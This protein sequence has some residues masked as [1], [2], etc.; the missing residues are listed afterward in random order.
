MQDDPETNTR[1]QCKM[2]LKQSWGTADET[3]FLEL[4]KR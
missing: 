3:S 2:I 4:W 1:F